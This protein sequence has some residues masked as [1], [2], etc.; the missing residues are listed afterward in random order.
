MDPLLKENYPQDTKIVAYADDIALLVAGNTRQE[1][2]NKT[3]TALNT[4]V[5]W[6]TH[7]GLKFSKEK[8]V[9]VPLKGGLVPGFTAVF[10]EGRIRSVQETRYL[11]LQLSEGLSFQNHAIKLLESSADVFSRLKSVR[12]SKWGVSAAL[13]LLI[14]K[15]VYIPRISYGSNIWYPSAINSHIQT[16]METAQRRVLI[17]IT[18]AYNTVSTRALQVIAGTPPIF[19]H[20]ESINRIRNGMTKKESEAILVE[21]WQALGCILQRTLDEEVPAEHQRK[22]AYP[23][24]L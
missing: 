5:A 4:I 1:I 24:Y 12:K 13:S 14:Y 23:D 17:A 19:L 15:A 3:E 22:N 18:G 6:A 2:V 8:S 20:I 21:Q 11:G 7:R 16:K 10:D 9:M